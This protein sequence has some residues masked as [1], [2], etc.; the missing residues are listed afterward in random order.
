[1]AGLE[2]SENQFSVHVAHDLSL[3][4]ALIHPEAKQHLNNDVFWQM[5]QTFTENSMPNWLDHNCFVAKENNKVICL[6]D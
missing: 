6:S 3:I 5:R 1:M 2:V 4:V